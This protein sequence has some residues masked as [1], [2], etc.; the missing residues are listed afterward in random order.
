MENYNIIMAS[1]VQDCAAV[2]AAEELD[3]EEET[4]LM[5][6]GDKIGKSCVRTLVRS[7]NGVVVNPFPEGQVRSKY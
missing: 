6:D 7:K 2:K 5:H 3:L 1:A 4:C